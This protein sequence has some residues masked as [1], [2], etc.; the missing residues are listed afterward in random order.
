MR[1]FEIIGLAIVTATAFGVWSASTVAQSR[2]GKTDVLG[3]SAPI[4]PQAIMVK[5]GSSLPS[6]GMVRPCSCL[7]S[8]K[9]P[10]AP[11]QEARHGCDS[12]ECDNA[13]EEPER[14]YWPKDDT[15]DKN[16]FHVVGSMVVAQT[17]CGRS[18]RVVRW[19]HHSLWLSD[20]RGMSASPPNVLQNYF[21]DQNE[22][23]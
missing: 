18:G 2:V 1:K 3:A 7:A 11:R 9:L 15:A 4:S 5:L 20:V 22:H 14:P 17:C 19:K 16:S 12:T 6:E 23:Y 8:D 13:E 10:G 21:H